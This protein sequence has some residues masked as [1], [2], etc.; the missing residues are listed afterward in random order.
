MFQVF[1]SDF[2]THSAGRPDHAIS[3]DEYLLLR[4]MHHRMANTLTLLTSLLWQEFRPASTPEIRKSLDRCEARIAAFGKLHHLLTVGTTRSSIDV[5][6]Y[7]EPLCRALSEAL[8]RP[9]GARCEVFVSAG[10]MR[11]ERCER[12]GLLITELVTN[13]AKH[14]FDGRDGGLVRIEVTNQMGH[15]FCV[16]SDN[17]AGIKLGAPNGGSS[18]IEK[19]VRS[20]GG[21]LTICSNSRGTSVMIIWHPQETFAG[22]VPA[23]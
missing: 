14:A 22:D 21:K 9:I 10:T 20:I 4:E 16:V 3:C 5:R 13:A 18:I 17:G 6:K 23:Q 15:W 19:I 1:A 11:A 7:I 2:S 12:L 8:L